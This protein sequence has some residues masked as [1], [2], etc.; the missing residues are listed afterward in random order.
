ME[1]IENYGRKGIFIETG[2]NFKLKSIKTNIELP[3]GIFYF[4][5]SILNDL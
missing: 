5:V 3:F 1:T 2:T 4:S